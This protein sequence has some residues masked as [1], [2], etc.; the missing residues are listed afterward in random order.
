M[1][2]QK[3]KGKIIF[4]VKKEL[5][6]PD[7][8]I[9]KKLNRIYWWIIFNFLVL[10]TIKRHEK[11]ENFLIVTDFEL[12]DEIKKRHERT[13]IFED[14]MRIPEA[15][16]DPYTETIKLS[17]GLFRKFSYILGF[18]GFDL[19]EYVEE[20]FAYDL[21]SLIDAFDM[22]EEI[23]KKEGVKEF[24]VLNK[25]DKFSKIAG[26]FALTRAVNHI[27]INAL[28]TGA[29][30]KMRRYSLQLRLL[31]APF[32][33]NQEFT[34]T[35]NKISNQN[36]QILF[37]AFDK[38]DLVRMSSL[39]ELAKEKKRE[40][41]VLINYKDARK[42]LEEK[43]IPFVFFG[44]FI[45]KED[46]DIIWQ[47]RKELIREWK[48]IKKSGK[49]EF[50]YKGYN[51]W[52]V[53][54]PEIEYQ[55]FTRFSWIMHFIR[56]SRNLLKNNIGIILTRGD[57]APRGRSLV[58]IGRQY[59]IPSLLVQPGAT[60]ALDSGRG[61]VPLISDRTAVWGQATKDLLIKFGVKP[62]KISIT[63]SA[64]FD[65]YIKGQKINE[66]I[67]KELGIEN[68]RFFLLATQPFDETAFSN[69]ER[70]EIINA[71]ISLMREFPDKY[72]VISLHPREKEDLARKLVKQSNVTNIKIAKSGN[73]RSF[74]EKCDLIMTIRSTTALEAMIL[75][76]PLVILNMLNCRDATKMFEKFNTAK[77]V[78]NREEF[79][80]I[81]REVLT[82]KYRKKYAK[83][84]KKFVNWYFHKLDGRSTERVINLIESMMKRS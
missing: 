68:K 33:N 84:R 4:L 20:E 59:G 61:F 57:L 14:Y 73:I 55:F 38:I 19:G 44:D 9:F 13:K 50:F 58:M 5:P 76:K 41:V 77:R 15:H 63:G 8:W 37:A 74:L 12:Y 34:K 35:G 67:F 28:I 46:R 31:F 49:K 25:E 16:I 42:F 71:L 22:I 81:I 30:Q 52:E 23:S 75:N 43:G 17:R 6:F 80:K 62:E 39:I 51:L 53:I 66:G 26:L 47:K 82:E 45:E 29:K 1:Q 7:F 54:E 69:K 2:L 83:N 64:E 3:N 70:M 18:E 27:D 11:E 78:R 60:S 36:K 65:E 10:G 56:A 21:I 32:I 40:F 72:L 24:I 48:I 79:S